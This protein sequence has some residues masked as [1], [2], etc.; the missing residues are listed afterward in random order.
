VFL[1]AKVLVIFIKSTNPSIVVKFQKVM[2]KILLKL[3]KRKLRQ[4]I[5]I[6]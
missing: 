3:S 5:K 4:L 1:E 6:H 2:R